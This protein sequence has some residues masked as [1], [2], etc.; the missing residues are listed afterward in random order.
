[1][2]NI[3]KS[4]DGFAVRENLSSSFIQGKLLKFVD[5]RFVVDKT[6][7]LPANVTLVALNAITCWV[8]WENGKPIDHRVTKPGQAHPDRDELPDQDES[9][10][11]PGLNGEPEDVWKD[12]RYLHLIDPQ[13]GA[14]FTFVS[15]SHGGRRGVSNLKSQIYYVR[16]AH[17]AALPVVQLASAPMKT[18]FGLKKRP[19]FRV[20]AWRGRE[21]KGPVKVIEPK[22]RE[23]Q[24]DFVEPLDDDIPF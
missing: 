24:G 2:S 19:D 11:P 4:D 8:H 15:D 23:P 14:D 13:T 10:R 6:E 1:M 12:T 22:P 21:Q 5:G 20:V 3:A 16:M 17:P 9:Q 18:K 7:E